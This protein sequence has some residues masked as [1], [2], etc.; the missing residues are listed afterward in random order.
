MIRVRKNL[1]DI[2]ASLL[3]RKTEKRRNTCIKD[4][5]YHQD[6]RFDERFKQKDIKESLSK[7]YHQKCAFCEQKIEKCIDNNL[8]ECSSTVEHYRPKSKYYWL[9]FSWDNLLWCC[10]KC[11]QNKGNKF[12]TK[13]REVEYNKEEFKDNIHSSSKIYHSIEEPKIINPEIDNIIEKINFNKNG[14]I[15]SEDERVKYT[16]EICGLDRESLNEKRQKVIDDFI[17]AI[18]NKKLKNEPIKSVLIKWLEDIKSKDKEFIALRYWVLK[19]YKV[20]IG[21]N[22]R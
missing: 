18:N 4:R 21:K 6:K 22:I 2:P 3:E 17:K 19:N 14:I 15:D 16:I 5:K 8:Q 13:K 9:A 7:I 11:N 1:N 20:L 10:H 12:E